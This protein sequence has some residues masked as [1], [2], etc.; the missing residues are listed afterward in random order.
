MLYKVRMNKSTRLGSNPLAAP[1]DAIIGT[2]I[3][4]GLWH[5]NV[6]CRTILVN[7]DL[8]DT[9]LVHDAVHRGEM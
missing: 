1:V 3:L 8:V 9:C 4:V 7:R 5:H 2:F 6:K